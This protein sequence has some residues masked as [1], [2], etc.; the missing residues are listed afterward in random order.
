MHIDIDVINGYQNH[1]AGHVEMAWTD[2][3]PLF[4][5]VLLVAPIVIAG[6]DLSPVTGTMSQATK[7]NSI[8]RLPCGYL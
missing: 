3:S 6:R 7:T 5:H 1:T 2:E 4:W 8:D